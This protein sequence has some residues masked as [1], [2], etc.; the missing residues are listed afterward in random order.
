[1]AGSFRAYAVIH[2]A[3]EKPVGTLLLNRRAGYEKGSF[4]FSM[5]Q[6][7]GFNNKDLSYSGHRALV[8]A[9]VKHV[10]AGGEA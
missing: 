2:L 9:F 7:A 6:F 8:D 4:S 5:S 1:M 10:N 3:S